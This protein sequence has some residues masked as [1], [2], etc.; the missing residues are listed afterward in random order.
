MKK[1]FKEMVFGRS[2]RQIAH[3]VPITEDQNESE[4]SSIDAF[5]NSD[6]DNNH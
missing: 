5:N 3:M 4:S 1:S 6:E 2:S